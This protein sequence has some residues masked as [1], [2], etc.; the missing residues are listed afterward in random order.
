MNKIIQ[1]ELKIKKFLGNKKSDIREPHA[2]PNC[3][4][5]SREVYLVS[6]FSVVVFGSAIM[7]VTY[8]VNFR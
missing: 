1:I 4:L 7:L 2:R 6:W 5:F 8:F 3:V